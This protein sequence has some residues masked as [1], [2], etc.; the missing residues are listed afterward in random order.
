MLQ[1]QVADAPAEGIIDEAQPLDVHHDHRMTRAGTDRQR[2]QPLHALAEQWPLGKAGLRI[3]VRQEARA[4]VAL[5]ILQAEG[6]V[7]GDIAQHS[8]LLAADHIGVARRQHQHRD[9]GAVDGQ[10]QHHQCA[11]LRVAHQRIDPRIGLRTGA[12]VA[13][14]FAPGLDHVPRRAVFIRQR[15]R[16]PIA[17]QARDVGVEPAPGDRLDAGRAGHFGGRDRGGIAAFADSKA[18]GLAQQLVAVADAQ[19]QPVD[20]AE[21][22]QHPVQAGDLFLLADALASRLR[23]AQ[24]ALDGRHQAR[25]VLL[26]HIVDRAGAQCLDRALL[27][28]GARQE[29]ERHVGGPLAG[30]AQRGH[31]VELRQREI[32]EHQLG[33]ELVQLADQRRLGLDPSPVTSDVRAL[34]LVGSPFRILLDVFDEEDADGLGRLI[35]HCGTVSRSKPR[36][37][38]RNETLVQTI[39]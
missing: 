3:E 31:A 18:A 14:Q 4:G 11:H 19:H 9:G 35:V 10:R 29:Q 21:H 17:E 36:F 6:K 32:G 7:A 15:P 22:A 33:P 28:D 30:D 20:A 34:D 1:Q 25:E 37:P 16:E 27:A 12:V 13:D 24:R 8:Q 38:G 39:R 23:L 5:Q 2:D 26:Q